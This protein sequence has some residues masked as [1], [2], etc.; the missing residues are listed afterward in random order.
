[1]SEDTGD[2]DFRK[3]SGKTLAYVRYSKDDGYGNF[4]EFRFT[5]GSIFRLD[6]RARLNAQFIHF[7]DGDPD[8]STN[9]GML[10]E[11]V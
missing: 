10:G 11:G 4:L 3:T 2:I 7:K 9:D 8:A 6:P 1:M 5:D